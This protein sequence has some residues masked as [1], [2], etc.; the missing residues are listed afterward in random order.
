M[1]KQILVLAY[2][3]PPYQGIGARRWA[4]FPKYLVKKNMTV[5]LITNNW[6]LQGNQ[7]W[8]SDINGKENVII[9]RYQTPFNYLRGHFSLT[10]KIANKA[11][12]V[13]SKWFT[14]TDEAYSFYAFNFKKICNYIENHKIETVIATGG[15]FSA[16]YFA[17][18]LKKK[19]DHIKV[20]QDFRDLWTEEEPYFFEYKTRNNQHPIY[21]KELKLEEHSLKYCDHIVSVTPGC[22]LR[23]KQKAEGYGIL[24]KSYSLIENGYDDDDR[25]T[26]SESEYPSGVYSK[27]NLNIVYFGTAGFGREEEFKKFIESIES[28]LKDFPLE[29]KFHFFGRFEEPMK[30]TILELPVS[31]FI[32]FHDA[33][34]TKEIQLY[35]YFADIHFSINDPISYFAYGSKI[36]D[37][38]MY[39][40]PLI[41]I[42]KIEALYHIIKDNRI[43]LVTDNSE[44]QNK[45]LVKTLASNAEIIK[46]GRYFSQDYGFDNFSIANLAERY[47]RIIND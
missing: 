20:I 13:F 14:W 3:F 39:K 4:K 6:K 16:N 45:E 31:K 18:L 10:D 5:H 26:F 29:P 1:N 11:E 28:Y 44:I 25:R 27:N 19:Y 8:I 46:Q 2:K 43:G 15:P 30:R 9:I 7:S 12:H 24:N 37:A 33:L 41:L 40:K 22:L 34:S 35:M 32:K 23:F 38:F 21:K 42:S 47:A 17:S 36:F